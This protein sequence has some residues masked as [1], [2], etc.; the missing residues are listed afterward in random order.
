MIK[1]RYCSALVCSGE[2][3]WVLAEITQLIEWHPTSGTPRG[4]DA[5]REA[6]PGVARE[7]LEDRAS[8]LFWKCV[9]AARTRSAAP[10]RK[11]A[12]PA[13]AAR[14]SMLDAAAS[15]RDFAVGGADLLACDPGDDFDYAYVKIYWSARFGGSPGYT[16]IENVLKLAR[17]AGVASTLS[18]TAVVC[19][20]C[21]A[22]LAETDT[23]R[24]DHCGAE[25]AAGDQAWVLDDMLPPGPL[26]LRA[27]APLPAWLVPNIADPRERRVLFARMAQLMASAGAIDRREKRLLAM[28][29]QRWGIPDDVVRQVIAQPPSG[30]DVSALVSASPQWFLAGLVAAALADGKLDRSERMML[31]RV[32]RA[33]A[34]PPD[35]LERQIASCAERLRAERAHADLLD[36]AMPKP[37]DD[38][39][40]AP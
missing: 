12:S 6:D 14:P 30:D 2:H 37:R 28:C 40:G 25:L 8:Y 20:A 36:T 21:G 24:C 32:C 35:E 23:T 29:A 17:K 10:L 33:L 16:P 22:P 9:Q 15:G 19:Q 27:Q 26:A 3:D 31:E 5:L 7:V 11:C 39:V 38:N 18:M 13:F 1:C 4:L 34:L